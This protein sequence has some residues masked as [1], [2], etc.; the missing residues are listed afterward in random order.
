MAVVQ[1]LMAVKPFD[2]CKSLSNAFV[3]S[4]ESKARKYNTV[5]VVFDN[6]APSQNH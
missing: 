4:I 6:Y 5:T 2:N 3:L 1:E